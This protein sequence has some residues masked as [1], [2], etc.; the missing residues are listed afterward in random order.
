MSDIVKTWSDTCMMFS[1]ILII[2]SIMVGFV[3]SLQLY[4][5]SYEVGQQLDPDVD[6]TTENAFMSYIQVITGLSGSLTNLWLFAMGVGII[7]FGGLS[8]LSGSW[9]PLAIYLFSSVFWTSFIKASS[10]LSPYLPAV[11]VL[12]ITVGFAFVYIGAVV[13]ILGSGA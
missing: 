10:I 8:I 2:F 4:P 11:F 13:K 6:P 9:T 12:A 1:I 3:G 5:V 7:A